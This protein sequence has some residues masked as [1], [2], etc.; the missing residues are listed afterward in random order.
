MMYGS[1]LALL[2]IAV[3][4]LAPPPSSTKLDDSWAKAA[5]ATIGDDFT[6]RRPSQEPTQVH[7]AEDGSALY[8]AFVVPQRENIDASQHTNGSSVENDD[9]VAVFLSPQGTQGFSYAFYANPNGARYQTSSENSAYSPEWGAIAER[10]ASGYTV[11]MRIPLSIIRN[12][13]SHVWKAQFARFTVA[14]NSVDVWAYAPNATSVSDPTFFGIL[15]GIGVAPTGQQSAARNPLRLQPYALGEAT[16][17]ANGGSTSRIGADFSIPF[18]P[19]ASFVGTIHPDYSNVESD[20]QTIA[21]TAFARQYVEVRPFFTQISSFFN[22]HAGCVNCPQTL[23]TPAIPIFSQGYGVE[24]TQ[25]RV[26]FAGFDA[27][28]D[29]RTD[30]ADTLNYG[31][32]DQSENYQINAQRVDVDAY[33]LQDNTVTLDGGYMNDHTHMLVYSNN[34]A[35]SGTLVTDPSLA[36]YHDYGLGYVTALTTALVGAQRIGAQFDPL[37]GY[38][39]QSD[40]LGYQGYLMQ[41]VNFASHDLLHDIALS[42]YFGRYDNHYGERSQTDAEPEINFDFRDLMT[43]HVYSGM[44]YIRTYANELLPFDQNGAMVGYRFNTNTPTYV[45]Y[46]GGPYYHGML[47]AWTYLTTLPVTRRIHLALETD[48]DKYTTAYTSEQSTNQWLERASLDWQFSRVLQFDFGVRRITGANL[49]AS[50][51]ALSYGGAACAENPY[52]P[53]CYV[54]AGNVSVAAHF[55]Y[56][57]NEFYLVYGNANNLA[58]EPALFFKWIRYIG[59][60]KGT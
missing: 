31:Y 3:P 41:M 23:Y 19:T 58:T 12:G 8:V 40:L 25:G 28:G 53:G 15:S 2:T 59:A 20:Q 30:Q 14:T 49:P 48:E 46:T 32:S 51:A 4:A 27:L 42:G 50:Y 56:A 29:D 52:N 7:V 26:T 21:P 57:R 10:S 43:V 37:D 55:L 47:D 36:T 16:S 5:T 22:N 33:G 45:S 39:A 54:D 24:G 1:L 35:E 34:G 9:Y 13:G 44:S 6:Y 38:T 11:T 60:E 17:A 18:T